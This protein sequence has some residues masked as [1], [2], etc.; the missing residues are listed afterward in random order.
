MIAR[1]HSEIVIEWTQRQIS[2]STHLTFPEAANRGLQGLR[3]LSLESRHAE[4]MIRLIENAGGEAISAPSMREVPLHDNAPALR[5]AEELLAGRFDLLICL[6]GVGTRILFDAIATQHARPK[7]V[8]AL[9]RLAVVARGPKAVS[10]LRQAGVPVTIAVPE[11]NTWRDILTALAEHPTLHA[12]EGKRIAIQE[13]GVSNTDLIRALEMQG[14][15]VTSVPVYQ[16]ALPENLQPLREAVRAI[17][18]GKI[19]VLLTTS[20]TQVHHLMQAAAESGL[21]EEVRTG[22]AQGVV[23]SVGPICSEALRE[24]GIA[25]DLEPTHSKMGQLLFE[26]AAKARDLLMRKRSA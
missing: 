15:T 2:W 22:L 1:L 18:D 8:E 25:V 14:A 17:A 11:P 19:D 9:S 4:Q 21:E 16:W 10:A 6:T 13:Y 7:I 24:H 20:A 5:F 3:V 12:L 26:T 23:A